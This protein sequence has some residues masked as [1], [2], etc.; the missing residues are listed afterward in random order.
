MSDGFTITCN[1][2]GESV[3]VIQMH[4]EAYQCYIFSESKIKDNSNHDEIRIT[5]ECGNEI[6]EDI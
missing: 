2:C 4:Y 6:I 3:K 5:C 1:K